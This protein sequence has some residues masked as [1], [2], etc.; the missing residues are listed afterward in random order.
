M[1]IAFIMILLATCIFNLGCEKVSDEAVDLS[2]E[3]TWEG[4]KRC[5]W[6]NPKIEIGKI[7]EQTKYIKIHMFDHE[8]DFDHG[9]VTYPYSGENVIPVNRFKE[10]QGPCPPLNPGEYKITIKALDADKT[11]IGIGEKTRYFPE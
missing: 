4:L 1:R 2:V 5:G 10:I 11:V 7:P 8:Y 9:T 3:Y 6:G